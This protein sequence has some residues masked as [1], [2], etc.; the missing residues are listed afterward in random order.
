MPLVKLSSNYACPEGAA[1][2]GKIIRV[3]EKEAVQLCDGPKSYGERVGI[4]ELPE[5]EKPIDV[6]TAKQ[7]SA[8]ATESDMKGKKKSGG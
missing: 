1:E 8:A 4:A 2:A 5:G 6:E 7:Q 3:T